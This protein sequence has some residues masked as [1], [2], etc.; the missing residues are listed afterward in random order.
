MHSF[1]PQSLYL[2]SRKIFC[3]IDRCY[4]REPF[5]SK[6]SNQIAL[7]EKLWWYSIFFLFP[8]I[9]KKQQF[10]DPI[11]KY[12]LHIRSLISSFFLQ[13]SI[14]QTITNI[15]VSPTEWNV[16][17]PWTWEI[18]CVLWKTIKNGIKIKMTHTID[19]WHVYNSKS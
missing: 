8:A 5:S 4:L 3:K 6:R 15:S 18:F 9:Q 11:N 14:I 12:C 16:P 13:W 17:L 7:T 10:T 2:V 1:I 19:F